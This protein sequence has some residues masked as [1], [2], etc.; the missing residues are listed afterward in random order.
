MAIL[1]VTQE[2]AFIGKVD[3]RIHVKVE[4]EKI[5]DA[6]FFE[7]GRALFKAEKIKSS[8]GYLQ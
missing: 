3:E 6:I 1:Y 4:K 2:N 5:L 7:I 8:S